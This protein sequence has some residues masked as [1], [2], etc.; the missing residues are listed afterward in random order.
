MFRFQI[1]TK[2]FH[3]FDRIVDFLMQDLPGIYVLMIMLQKI[4]E[5][6]NSQQENKKIDHEL[7][8][9]KVSKKCRQVTLVQLRSSPCEIFKF[10]NKWQNVRLE[11]HFSYNFDVH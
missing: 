9:K 3:K 5:E 10:F 7:G 8:L 2:V 1:S 4:Q 11:I 6:T